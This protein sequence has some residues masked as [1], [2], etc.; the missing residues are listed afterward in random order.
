MMRS[1]HGHQVW[2]ALEGLLLPAILHDEVTGKDTAVLKFYLCSQLLP[3]QLLWCFLPSTL[4]PAV[5]EH[6]GQVQ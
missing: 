5:V 1:C 3:G 2:Y 4:L 6:Q